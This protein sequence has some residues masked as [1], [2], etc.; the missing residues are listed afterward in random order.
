MQR[1]LV[2]PALISR[3]FRRRS[4]SKRGE[5]TFPPL[6]EAVALTD[7]NTR[8][9]TGTRARVVT[10][11]A[12]SISSSTGSVPLVPC[13]LQARIA[14]T[15]FP[16]QTDPYTRSPA[17]TME[18]LERGSTLCRHSRSH[19]S[20][21]LPCRFRRTSKKTLDLAA[22]HLR[23]YLGHRCCLPHRYVQ[24]RFLHFDTT[25]RKKGL[26]VVSSQIP[27]HFSC[28]VSYSSIS[29]CS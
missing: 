17:S 25:L 4:L 14:L 8:Y 7:Q 5:R 29:I 15:P 26:H 22:S 19:R 24:L 6:P 28:S 3:C 12:V 13:G 11:L 27:L 1:L 10:S 16:A 20:S 2:L 18:P 9:S 21:R 23:I